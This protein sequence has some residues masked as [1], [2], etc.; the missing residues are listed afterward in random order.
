MTVLLPH[1][2][3]M[4]WF[5]TSGPTYGS[6]CSKNANFLPFFLRS[7]SRV[8][9][10]L[11]PLCLQWW[12]HFGHIL[13]LLTGVDHFHYCQYYFPKKKKP[14]LHRSCSYPHIAPLAKPSGQDTRP[15]RTWLTA[16]SC[17][18]LYL[19]AVLFRADVSIPVPQ[20]ASVNISHVSILTSHLQQAFLCHPWTDSYQTW[21][22]LCKTCHTR[23]R[24]SWT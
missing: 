14:T 4:T 13:L 1:L 7:S 22:L 17:S 3:T 2:E 21:G 16:T 18:C 15:H 10:H 23:H 11:R 24:T 8:Q 12:L 6:R 19:P 5:P 9:P 20:Y